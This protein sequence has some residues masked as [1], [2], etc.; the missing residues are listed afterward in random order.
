MSKAKHLYGVDE[1]FQ[2]L[3]DIGAIRV[4][5][6]HKVKLQDQKEKLEAKGINTY[7]DQAMWEK[8][9]KGVRFWQD[10]IDMVYRNE[11]M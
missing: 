4:Y 6:K 7:I 10:L 11:N 3:R 5:T 8:M 9:D 2:D 1:T